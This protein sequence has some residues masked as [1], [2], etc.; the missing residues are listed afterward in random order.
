MEVTGLLDQT[1]FVIVLYRQSLQD[2]NARQSLEPLFQKYTDRVSI[3]VY[4]NS[5]TALRTTQSVSCYTH[6]AK[7]SGVSHAYNRAFQ[8]ATKNGYRF[9][10]LMD[11][12]STFPTGIFETYSHAVAAHPDVHVFAPR[13]ESNGQLYSPFRLVQGRGVAEVGAKPGLYAL[14]DIKFINSG[15]LVGLDAFKK[16]EGYD[17]RFPLDFSDIVFC[18]RLSAKN[19]KAC[20]IDG[21]ISHD[22][23]SSHI[24]KT[25]DHK[26]RFENYLRALALY[27]T[28][29]KKASY[30]W[31]GFPRAAKLSIQLRDRWFLKKFFRLRV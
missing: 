13:A 23:S 21:T 10:M 25:V 16:C 3:F 5:E 6:D 27:K 11:Q 19:F 8:F 7:N 14:D 26:K 18:D 20:L 12:D 31:G 29:N 9:L 1:L 17:E 30:W 24:G 2:S 28:V 15:L 4:D 22:H